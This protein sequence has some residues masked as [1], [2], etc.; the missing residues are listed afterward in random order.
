MTHGPATQ[1]HACFRGKV[2]Q[3]CCFREVLPKISEIST[4]LNSVCLKSTALPALKEIK[5]EFEIRL[6]DIVSP[7]LELLA[8]INC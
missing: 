3:F 2:C 5:K 6:F 7:R 4:I 8:V 1:D